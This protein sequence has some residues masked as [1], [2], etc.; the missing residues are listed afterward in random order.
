MTKGQK[1]QISLDPAIINIF[2]TFCVGEVHE[3]CT[4][5]KHNGKIYRAHPNYRNM[6]PW[7][8]FVNVEYDVDGFDFHSKGFVE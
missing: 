7:Y 5:I 6:G 1:F 4:E 2:K 8:D 3:F